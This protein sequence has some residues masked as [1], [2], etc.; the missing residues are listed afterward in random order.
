MYYLRSKPATNAIKFTVDVEA[1]ANSAGTDTDVD[2]NLFNTQLNSNKENGN[3]DK[4]DPAKKTCELLTR[5]RRKKGE[6]APTQQEIDECLMC[7]S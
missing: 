6:P 1:L 2:I 5:K 7:G 3:L 4:R